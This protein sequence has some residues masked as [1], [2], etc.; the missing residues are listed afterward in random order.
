[1]INDIEIDSLIRNIPGHKKIFFKNFDNYNFSSVNGI[2]NIDDNKS[3][4]I[5]REIKVNIMI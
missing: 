4:H 2:K 5:I 1:M 3:Y